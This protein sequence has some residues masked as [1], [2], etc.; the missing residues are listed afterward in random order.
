MSNDANASS[1]S[2]AAL[3]SLRVMTVNV[4]K[5]FTML[6]RR[7]VL[8]E[9]RDAIREVGADVVF[10]QEIHGARRALVAGA[11]APDVPHYEYLA[12]EIWPAF[13]YGRNAVYTNGDHGNA[14]LSK[15]PIVRSQNVDVSSARHEKRGLLHCALRVPGRDDVVHAICVHLGLKQS[16]RQC[17]CSSCA[18]SS[19][20]GCPR[21]N[22]C[23]WPVTSTT[24]VARRTRCCCVVPIW[25]KSS[26]K[27]VVGRR[28]P[29]PHGLPL[30][31][32]DRIYVRGVRDH[33]PLALPV[34]PWTQSVRPCADRRGDPSVKSTWL[35]GKQRTAAGE[36]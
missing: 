32:L 31:P 10:L 3:G 21:P 9:L 25:T 26:S 18:S 28:G 11:E 5:G 6:N 4:H 35:S 20:K 14:L 12:D 36:R 27:P 16:H 23:S 8:R 30:L 19:R 33:A 34:R 17:S 13:A 1:F 24:G 22:R 29:F 7:F 2:I 15:Y